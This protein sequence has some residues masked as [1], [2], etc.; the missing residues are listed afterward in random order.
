MAGTLGFRTTEARGIEPA[1]LN[2]DKPTDPKT[3]T[4]FGGVMFWDFEKP[5]D[6]LGKD[7]PCCLIEFVKRLVYSDSG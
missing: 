7:G 6:L 3:D 4:D 2:S 1:T 5:A